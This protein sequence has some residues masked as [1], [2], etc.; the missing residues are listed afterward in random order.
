MVNLL[1]NGTLTVA[2]VVAGG[3]AST[4]LFNFNGGTLKATA[5]NTGGSFMT[6]GNVDAVTVYSGGG[7][8]DNNGT[9][10]TVSNSLAGGDR[11]RRDLDR[12]DQRW[13]R[14]HRRTPWSRSQA[15]PATRRLAMR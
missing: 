5:T 4:A 11:Q 10:I 14:L 2:Q 15:A 12:S 1:N 7:T 3:A 6:S 9:S 13:Q 8:I